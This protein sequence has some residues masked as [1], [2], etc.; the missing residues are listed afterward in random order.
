MA[1]I[2]IGGCVGMNCLW[3]GPISGAAMNPARTF[4]PSVFSGGMAFE[5]LWIYCTAPMIGAALAVIVCRATHEEGQC[6]RDEPIPP[7]SN[8]PTD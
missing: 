6:C 8:E 1:G 7:E 4:G 3:A 2:A 5:T